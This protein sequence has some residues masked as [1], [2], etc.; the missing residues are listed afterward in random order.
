MRSSIGIVFL[1]RHFSYGGL[2]HCAAG[3]ILST[4]AQDVIRH[5]LNH[6]APSIVVITPAPAANPPDVNRLKRFIKLTWPAAEIGIANA[7]PSASLHWANGKPQLN[8]AMPDGQKSRSVPESVRNAPLPSGR[9]LLGGVL[10]Y[11]GR[12]SVKEIARAIAAA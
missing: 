2:F 8:G 11:G 9:E 3:G 1:T 7:A 6:V 4:F 12:T 5:M 10:Y